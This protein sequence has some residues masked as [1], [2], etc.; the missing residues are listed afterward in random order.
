VEAAALIV[1]VASLIVTILVVRA[2]RLATAWLVAA[3]GIGGALAAALRST[4]APESGVPTSNPTIS[5]CGASWQQSGER[6]TSTNRGLEGSWWPGGIDQGTFKATDGSWWPGGPSTCQS[7]GLVN[8]W[9]LATILLLAILLF[10]W[11]AS[12]AT[13]WIIKVVAADR[14]RA[15]LPLLPDLSRLL[16]RIAADAAVPKHVRISLAIL[17]GY[18][19]LP[20]DFAP[21][22]I[23]GL[24]DTKDAILAVLAVRWIIYRA[25]TDLLGQHWP[26]SPDGLRAVQRLADMSWCP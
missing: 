20:I 1:S 19:V 7:S 5:S 23:P 17:I 9:W 25:G 14:L 12:V 22:R 15:V 13:L 21:K 3:V 2:R 10:L 11:L 24:R 8:N 26:G 16:H 6:A 4:D 18:S